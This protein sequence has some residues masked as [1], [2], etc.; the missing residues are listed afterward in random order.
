M[1]INNIMGVKCP[2]SVWLCKFGVTIIITV[3]VVVAFLN[4]RSIFSSTPTH[5][6]THTH[7]QRFLSKRNKFFCSEPWF[8][9]L[10]TSRGVGRTGELRTTMVEGGQPLCEGTF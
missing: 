1:S 2:A 6:R 9:K 4:V 5:A 8:L 3:V 10:S 7:T